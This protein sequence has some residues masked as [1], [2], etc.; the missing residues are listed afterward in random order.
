MGLPPVLY[1]SSIG[2]LGQS[3]AVPPIPEPWGFADQSCDSVSA[4]RPCTRR[5]AEDAT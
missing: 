2:W 1:Y 5:R 4:S 3:A